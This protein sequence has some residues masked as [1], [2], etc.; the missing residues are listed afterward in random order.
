MR[1]ILSITALIFGIIFAGC[2]VFGT[3]EYLHKDQGGITYVVVAGAAIAAAISLL[4]AWA[5]FAWRG[6]PLLSASIWVIF[7]VALASVV[8]SAL[9][10]TGSATDLA[11]ERRERIENTDAQIAQAHTDAQAR[12]DAANIA[13]DKANDD[14]LENASKKGC[15]SNCAALLSAAVIRA[16]KEVADARANLDK[17]KALGA[18]APIGKTDSL[19]KRIAAILPVSEDS[20]RLYQ[21]LMVP[22]LTSAMS[23]V[24]TALGIWG[25]QCW[26]LGLPASTAS[27]TKLATPPPTA[28]SPEPTPLAAEDAPRV[29]LPEI[30]SLS[31]LAVT[32]FDQSNSKLAPFAKHKIVRAPGAELSMRDVLAA[33][34][35]ACARER[36]KAL[37]ARAFTRELAVLC[38]EAG[39][40]V[41]VEGK[42]A[43]L[44]GAALAA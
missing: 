14:V 13:L 30:A 2:E 18:E 39:V 22:T 33:Y 27:K 29:M 28:S 23:A 43:Y 26:W 44:V 24:L 35:M 16:E 10:R 21:P 4:P 20:V 36:V 38:H 15:A 11:Q 32:P 31:E 25:L 40:R 3:F 5:S 19:A 8:A 12:L 1:L 6:R 9:A 7:V 37:D 41:R 34:Q 42:D 17:T